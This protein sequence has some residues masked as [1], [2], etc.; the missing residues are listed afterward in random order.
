MYL[1]IHPEVRVL[2]L[3]DGFALELMDY[4]QDQGKYVDREGRICHIF[5]PPRVRVGD[6]LALIQTHPDLF[7]KDTHSTT[8]G[9]VS[10]GED[11]VYIYRLDVIQK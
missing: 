3:P 5:Q 11:E 1:H 8:T 2:Q 9:Y 10:K 6:M 7:N 4:L